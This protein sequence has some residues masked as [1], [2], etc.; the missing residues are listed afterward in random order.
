MKN[1]KYLLLIPAFYFTS[2]ASKQKTETISVED[3][4]E[5]PVRNITAIGLEDLRQ[6]KIMKDILCQDWENAADAAD[7]SDLDITSTLDIMY[8]G[9]CFFADGTVLKNPRQDI[10][11]GKWILN[12]QVKPISISMTFD[13]G[14]TETYQLAYLSPDK[15]KLL[16]INEPEKI[17]TDFNAEAIR[18]TNLR[19]DPFYLSNILWRIKPSAPE[20]D[21]QIKQRLKSCIHFFVLFYQQKI[22]AKSKAVT[23]VGLP[24]CFTFYSGG[25]SVQDE[26][27][28][29]QKWTDCFYNREQALKAHQLADRLI[30]EHFKLPA[31][32]TNWLHANLAILKA[33]EER[34][35]SLN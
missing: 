24:T 25:V 11:I 12:D 10:A 35:D 32:A 29:T 22:D 16:K 20:T 31:S 6:S 14:K 4:A 19:E 3:P 1:Y 33:M 17:T 9:Y 26:N 34:I 8:R 23:F 30:R 27:K 5:M 18:N 15:M 2:C 13:N 7:A 21:K 28:L